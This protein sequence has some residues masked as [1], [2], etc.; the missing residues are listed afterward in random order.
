MFVSACAEKDRRT[1]IDDLV[2]PPALSKTPDVVI[3]MPA[4]NFRF[5]DSDF[6]VTQ[7]LYRDAMTD[8][9]SMDQFVDKATTDEL[10]DISNANE[11]RRLFTYRLV[12]T[13]GWNPLEV[14]S[15]RDLYWD[16][17]VK[18]Y[19]VPSDRFRAYYP[20]F[21]ALNI[22]GYNV[23]NM[24]TIEL[25]RSITVVEPGG[26]EVLFHINTL[27]IANA[28]NNS[29]ELAPAAKLKDLITEYIT[30]TPEKYDYIITAV[31]GSYF[32]FEWSD[33]VNGFF[34]VDE[35][36]TFV[37]GKAGQFRV[38]NPM[39]ISLVGID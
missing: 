5:A 30:K 31:N 11:S 2:Y 28:T 37:P 23:Q 4:S 35:D 6:T 21:S 16:E 17:F 36:R 22:N 24:G 3:E 26:K 19:L 20:D 25:F 7:I 38:R 12:A 10:T 29:G 13:D 34:F 14:R 1:G 32:T 8:V 27:T 15:L 39:R 33:M 9:I 18:G